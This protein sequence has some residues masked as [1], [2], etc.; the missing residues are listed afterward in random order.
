MIGDAL[1]TKTSGVLRPDARDIVNND[2]NPR[3]DPYGGRRYPWVDP[4]PSAIQINRRGTIFAPANTVQATVASFTVPQAMEGVITAVVAFFNG[5]GFNQG[6]A[7]GGAGN[8][9]WV[10]DI[11]NPLG[12]ATGYSPAD[13]S[14]ITTQLGTFQAGYPWPVP[15]GIR[16]SERDTIRFKVE[17]FAPVQVGTPAYVFCAFLGW[18]W[19]SRMQWGGAKELG[20]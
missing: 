1:L 19:P 12:A 20:T 11:N 10:I 17:T 8:I 2:G 5:A 18:Y 4:P 3:S 6:Q 7:A 14:S 13:F 16:L 15:G 9:T